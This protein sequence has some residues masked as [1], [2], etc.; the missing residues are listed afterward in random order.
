MMRRHRDKNVNPAEVVSSYLNLESRSQK[1]LLNIIKEVYWL[2][3]C[4]NLKQN[5]Y[6]FFTPDTILRDVMEHVISS[7]GDALYSIKTGFQLQWT[8]VKDRRALRPFVA[9]PVDTETRGN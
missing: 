4:V 2:A 9:S 7:L 8:H 5:R 3:L 6:V 1:G